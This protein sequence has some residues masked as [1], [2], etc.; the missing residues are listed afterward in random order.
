MSGNA[1]VVMLL[2]AALVWGGF[3]LILL[4]AVRKERSKARG[5]GAVPGPAGPELP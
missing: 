2:I 1:T 3:L 4:T 5:D